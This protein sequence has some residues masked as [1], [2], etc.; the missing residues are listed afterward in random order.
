MKMKLKLVP[1]LVPKL[2]MD[3]WKEPMM[4]RIRTSSKYTS[5]NFATL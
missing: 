2:V 4:T 3:K 5:F 1:K